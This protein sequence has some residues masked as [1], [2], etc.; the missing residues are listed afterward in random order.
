M[1]KNE[2]RELN[3]AGTVPPAPANGLWG[4]FDQLINT[5]G[6][7][8]VGIVVVDAQYTKHDTDTGDIAPTVRLRQFEFPVTADDRAALVAMLDRLQMDRTGQL[9]PDSVARGDSVTPDPPDPQ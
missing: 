7:T 4:I 1:A 3:I 2:D 8:H 5:P 9:I 6:Q